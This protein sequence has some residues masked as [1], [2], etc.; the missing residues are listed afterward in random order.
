MDIFNKFFF[1]NLISFLVIIFSQQAYSN[2]NNKLALIIA[3]GDY[4]EGTGW[5]DI[6]S[7][8]DVPLIKTALEKQGFK[9][10]D[11][12]RD[13]QA[14]KDG[15]IN[16]FKYLT[17]K[18]SKDDIIAIHFSSH[19]QQIFD[20]NGDEIDGLDEAIVSYGAHVRYSDDYKGEEHLRD[21][22]IGDLLEDLRMKLGTKGNVIVTIDACHSG[23]GTRGNEKV[24][25]GAAPLVPGD[26]GEIQIEDAVGYS[27]T[28]S[29]GSNSNLAP[30]IIFS[31]A[32]AN[33]LNF[34]YQGKGSLSYAISKAMQELEEGL[35]YRGLF[36]RVQT[37]M[38]D[39]AKRQNPVA[40]GNGLDA[41]LFGDGSVITQKAFFTVNKIDKRK[42]HLILDGGSL[43]GIH[44]NTKIDFLPSGTI[45]PEG[46]EPVTSG[47]VIESDYFTSIIKV[48]ELD[49]IKNKAAAWG[50]VSEYSF[51]ETKVKIS[52][53]GFKDTGLKMEVEDSL[54]RNKLAEFVDNPS[55]KEVDLWIDPSNSRGSEAEFTLISAADSSIYKN[56]V[57]LSDEDGISDLRTVINEFAQSKIL[58]E[59]KLVD[60]DLKVT[61]EFVPVKN[62]ISEDPLKFRDTLS[63]KDKTVHGVVKISEGDTLLLK[64]INHGREDAYFNIIGI[65]QDGYVY[66]LAPSYDESIG[67]TPTDYFIKAGESK[68]LPDIIVEMEPPYGK[69]ILKL[70]SYK[71]PIDFRRI[72]KARG[73]NTRSAQNP[74]ENFFQDGYKLDQMTRSPRLRKSKKQTAGNT[75]D[76][77]FEIVPAE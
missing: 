68:V 34:E 76:Y 57:V 44:K 50:F 72:F 9:I 52:L 42:K 1:F 14:T 3:I 56:E 67:D 25:G 63:I 32:R 16:A 21:D 59:T 7:D 28:V 17:A 13:E 29:R 22:T 20:D 2:S 49:K 5:Q 75:F 6:S 47:T 77:P 48:D 15:I 71:D 40:E 65:T 24:R 30:I 45:D 19:G 74:I 54:K 39:I 4:P 12:L 61:F 43:A 46:K 60:K 8:Q 55:S 53:R 11:I 36:A 62:L 51:P 27:E 23:T 33:E 18:A 10:N 58:R 73:A 31:A 26:F 35:T 66:V 64:V 38:A 70:F 37:I 69:E 41:L